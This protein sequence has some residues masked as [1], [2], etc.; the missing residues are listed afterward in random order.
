MSGPTLLRRMPGPR[1]TAAICPQHIVVELLYAQAHAGDAAFCERFHLPAGNGPG[2]AFEAHFARLVPRKGRAKMSHQRADLLRGKQRRRAA[3]HVGKRQAPVRES[4]SDGVGRCF[5]RQDLDIA[6]HLRAGAARVRAVIAKPAALETKGD[7]YIEPQRRRRGRSRAEHA[8][9]GGEVLRAPAG[10]GRVDRNE[11]IAYEGHFTEKG[12][13]ALAMSGVRNCWARDIRILNAD[14]GIFIHGSNITI[15]GVLL[16][17]TRSPERARGATG[18]HGIALGGQ[19]NL[20]RRFE[21]AT[22]FLHDLTVTRGSA[23]NVAASGSGVDLCFDH[24][25]YA[26]HSNLFTDIDLGEGSRMLQSG[27]GARLGGHSGAHERFRRQGER[28]GGG[29]KRLRDVQVMKEERESVLPYVSLI[30]SNLPI[31][32]RL[33]RHLLSDRAEVK[34]VGVAV[35]SNLDEVDRFRRRDGVSS[36]DSRSCHYF[37]NCHHFLEY[38]SLTNP[39]NSS[40]ARRVSSSHF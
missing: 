5:P 3:A 40:A 37:Q 39:R 28:A 19:D 21:I 13:N 16:A 17:S 15:E 6:L 9:H 8:S 29:N 18:R 4:R 25:R 26:P 10:E 36:N 32:L 22:R 27:G 38:K 2:S 24:H 1:N 30:V 12:Y 14:S 23:A 11:L 34:A 33:A 7:V 20:L 31:A 35:N